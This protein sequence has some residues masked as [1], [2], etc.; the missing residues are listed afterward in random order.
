M[1]ELTA[2]T[3]SW[4]SGINHLQERFTKTDQSMAELRS[5]LARQ[6]AM[7]PVTQ[8]Q[9]EA[10]QKQ[11]SKALRMATDSN[12]ALTSN[13]HQ[14]DILQ[15]QSSDTFGRATD[16]NA[17]LSSTKV[18]LT[19]HA[20]KLQA[21]EASLLELKSS[22]SRDLTEGL[23]K[24]QQ[25]CNSRLDLIGQEAGAGQASLQKDSVRLTQRLEG[26]VAQHAAFA[27]RL[28]AIEAKSAGEMSPRGIKEATASGRPGHHGHFG[29][30][31]PIG[32]SKVAGRIWLDCYAEYAQCTAG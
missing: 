27:E 25:T 1:A 15:K 28:I 13:H 21:L 23:A 11:S 18:Q 5:Q 14:L 8:D 3:A 10:V 19:S 7:P 32:M 9:L 17:A 4:D 2:R 22:S 30:L 16:T 20:E 31:A 24:V 12:A 6:A 29:H 26:L